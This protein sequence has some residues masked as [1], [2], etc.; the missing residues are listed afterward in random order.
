LQ[1]TREN[2]ACRN[3]APILRFFDN[4]VTRTIVQFI[5]LRG[6]ERGGVIMKEAT[7]DDALQTARLLEMNV[8]Y[9][10][11]IIRGMLFRQY[12]ELRIAVLNSPVGAST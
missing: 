10:W 9:V 12:C 11:R 3:L 7:Y 8:D 5:I 4:S 1:L 6:K 2:P